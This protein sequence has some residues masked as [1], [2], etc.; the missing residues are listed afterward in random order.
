MWKIKQNQMK[1]PE[2]DLINFFLCFIKLL[3][4]WWKNRKSIKWKKCHGFPITPYIS[5]TFPQFIIVVCVW[6]NEMKMKL[7]IYDFILIY[8][9]SVIFISTAN[10]HLFKF[11]N[12]HNSH[13]M[14]LPHLIHQ[15]R[16]R[17]AR[18]EN[19]VPI[20]TLKILW[21]MVGFGIGTGAEGRL[22]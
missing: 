2:S 17:V 13:S 22:V 16:V 20:E 8:M 18:R 4:C 11:L 12:W 21:A 10:I 9:K 5:R 3:N 6:S 1:Q 7:F 14:E 15:R 19:T